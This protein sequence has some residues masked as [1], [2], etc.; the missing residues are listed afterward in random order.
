MPAVKRAATRSTQ[1]SVAFSGYTWDD[2]AARY[3]NALGRF[4]SERTV[5]NELDQTLRNVATHVDELGREL[6]AGSRSLESWQQEMRDAVKSTH[7][8]SGALA[9]GGWAQLTPADYGRIGNR[10]RREY[11]FLNGFATEVALGV[12]PLNGRLLVRARLYA[13]SAR[14][15]YERVRQ[16]EMIAAGFDEERNILGPADHCTDCLFMSVIGWQPVGTLI[17]IGERQ[18]GPNCRCRVAYRRSEDAEEFDE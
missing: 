4:V 6:L 13:Q 5:R 18:C 16:A 14:S 12:Q 1:R 9:K 7:L 2:D 15:T 8:L 17:P 11:D 10:I 3:R